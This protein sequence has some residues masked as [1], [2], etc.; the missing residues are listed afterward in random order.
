MS[1][2]QEPSR[3]NMFIRVYRFYCDGFCSEG[4]FSLSFLC[5]TS[6]FASEGIF[7][8][9]HVILI[10]LSLVYRNKEDCSYRQLIKPAL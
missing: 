4:F 9:R 1:Q 3:G 5:Q 7:P 2:V 10:F 6:V 8:Y